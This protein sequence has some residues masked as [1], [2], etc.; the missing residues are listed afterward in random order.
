MT[1]VYLADTSVWHWAHHPV[2]RAALQTEIDRAAVATCAIIDAELIVSAR[3]ERE[4]MEMTAERRAL[5]WF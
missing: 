3:S 2:A 1:A 4:A 5:Q